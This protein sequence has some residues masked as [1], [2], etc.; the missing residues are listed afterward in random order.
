MT[1]D[2]RIEKIDLEL[3]WLTRQFGSSWED[4]RYLSAK[5]L[6]YEPSDIDVKL[7]A[8]NIFFVAYLFDHRLS[9]LL[10]HFFT[11]EP[12]FRPNLAECID[13]GYSD[14]EI[15]LYHNTI[16]DFIDWIIATQYSA[17]DDL[18][19]LRTYVTNPFSVIYL[20]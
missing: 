17:E 9:P 14:Q 7:A 11:Q 8:L 18:G 1:N 13:N 6:S 16:T 3:Q 10:E 15:V 20:V 12:I 4:W 2:S 19:N 5:W